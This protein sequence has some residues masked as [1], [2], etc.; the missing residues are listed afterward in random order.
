VL[1]ATGTVELPH[2]LSLFP[3]ENDRTP[4]LIASPS[5]FIDYTFA[6]KLNC[7]ITSTTSKLVNVVG[8]GLL[9]FDATLSSTHY[10]IQ[11]ESFTNEFKLLQLREYDIMHVS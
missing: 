8:G 3:S 5:C 4:H 1:F 6:S 11:H 2:L 7:P 9:H 10:I